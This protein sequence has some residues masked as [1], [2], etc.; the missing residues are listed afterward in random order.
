MPSPGISY[1]LGSTIHSLFHSLCPLGLITINLTPCLSDAAARS[2]GLGEIFTKAMDHQHF[3]CGT[4]NGHYSLW[5]Q[6]SHQCS[7]SMIP[8]LW[9]VPVAEPGKPTWSPVTL[10]VFCH[11]YSSFIS[12][13]SASSAGGQVLHVDWFVAAHCFSLPF[14]LCWLP[15]NTSNQG[16]TGK[17]RIWS[18]PPP[19]DFCVKLAS[20]C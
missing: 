4:P 3:D 19:S 10:C 16:A 18:L 11:L 2:A 7:V 6:W 14:L 12:H 13:K 20:L 17:C 8:M 9:L 1:W 5:P 15:Y